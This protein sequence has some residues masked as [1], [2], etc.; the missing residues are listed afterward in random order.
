MVNCYCYRDCGHIKLLPTPEKNW[1]LN[2]SSRDA[3]RPAVPPQQPDFMLQ[4]HTQ[5]AHSPTHLVQTIV[6]EVWNDG[7]LVGDLGD[8]GEGGVP[9]RVAGRM[10]VHAAVDITRRRCAAV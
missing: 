1:S 7:V 10:R 4:N 9:E 3:E 6:I 5:G 8:V 2:H